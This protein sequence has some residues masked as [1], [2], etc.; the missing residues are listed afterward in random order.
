MG[1]QS[2]SHFEQIDFDFILVI[3]L[4]YI[5]IKNTSHVFPI[6]PLNLVAMSV[7]MRVTIKN[8]T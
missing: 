8:K 7:G 4:E 6:L 5:M 2:F 3:I 1:V